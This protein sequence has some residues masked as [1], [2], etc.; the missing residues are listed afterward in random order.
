[1]AGRYIFTTPI[2]EKCGCYHIVKGLKVEGLKKVMSP[3]ASSE[4]DF[5]PPENLGEEIA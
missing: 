3:D 1:M 2:P 4:K 5:I